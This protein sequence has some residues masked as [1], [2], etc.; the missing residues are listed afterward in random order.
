MIKRGVVGEELGGRVE[1]GMAAGRK[2]E[3]ARL[4]E[5]RS[6]PAVC[7]GVGRERAVG[8]N[9]CD[10]AA[11]VLE[12]RRL[13]GDLL[14]ELLKQ[15]VFKLAALFFQSENLAFTLGQLVGDEPL[16]VFQRLHMRE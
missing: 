11:G 9:C 3:L 7:G 12:Q 15:L 13:P 4:R 16:G 8:V 2:G 10:G 1:T 14:A 5:R 6:T